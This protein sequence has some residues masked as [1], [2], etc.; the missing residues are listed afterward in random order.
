MAKFH[1]VVGQVNY[2]IEGDGHWL[3]LIHG[4]GA[5]LESWDGVVDALRGDYRL[6]RYDLRGHGDSAKLPGPY[7]LDDFIDDLAGLLDHLEIAKTHLAGFSLGGIIAQGFALAHPDRLDRLALVSAIAGRTEEERL[8]VLARAKALNQEGGSSFVS[9]S[10][11]RWFTDD[12][13][14]NNA[15]LIEKRLAR[16]RT[17]DPDCYRAAYRVLAESDLA[18]ELHKITAPTLVMTGEFDIGSNPRMSRLMA[19]RIP[20]SRLH[21]MAGLKHSVLIEAPDLVAA[22]IGALLAE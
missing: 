21:I 10:V 2:K 15:D 7:S 1:S 5:D 4:V 19:E 9:A 12:F 17:N 3:T 20:D 14:A 8:K 11:K 6:L 13:I 18:D 16:G 22:Q